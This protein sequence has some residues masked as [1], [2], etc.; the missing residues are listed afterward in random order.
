MFLAVSLFQLSLLGSSSPSKA[1]PVAN[2]SLP[3]PKHHDNSAVRS[4]GI[5]PIQTYDNSEG[6]LAPWEAVHWLSGAY[7]RHHSH[8]D[9][10][11]LETAVGTKGRLMECSLGRS[12]SK[13]DIARRVVGRLILGPAVAYIFTAWHQLSSSNVDRHQMAVVFHSEVSRRLLHEAFTEWW[14]S[15]LLQHSANNHCVSYHRCETAIRV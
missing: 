2:N 5:T 15:S 8:G 12:V 3:A 10:M 14:R 11:D 7:Q 9:V 13:R 1:L 6:V 4:T